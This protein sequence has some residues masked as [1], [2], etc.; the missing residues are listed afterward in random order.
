MHFFLVFFLFALLLFHKRK[1]FFLLDL[2][3]E[4]DEVAP[5]SA[6]TVI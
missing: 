3:S 2:P 6:V 4:Y 5:S 1:A